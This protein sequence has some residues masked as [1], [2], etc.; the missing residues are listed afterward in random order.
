MKFLLIFNSLFHRKYVYDSCIIHAPQLPS[1]M[2]SIP[3]VDVPIYFEV[4]DLCPL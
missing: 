4:Y 2:S 1:T 3:V